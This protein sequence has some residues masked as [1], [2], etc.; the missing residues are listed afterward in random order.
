MVKP[1]HRKC[2]HRDEEYIQK[3]IPHPHTGAYD[4]QNATSYK[5]YTIMVFIYASFH[6]VVIHTASFSPE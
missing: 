5:Q 3:G 4:I 1:G 2:I 6:E